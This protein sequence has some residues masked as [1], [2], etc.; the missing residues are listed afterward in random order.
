VIPKARC[1]Y[2]GSGES[3]LWWLLV[4]QHSQKEVVVDNDVHGPGSGEVRFVAGDLGGQ[5]GVAASLLDG[6]AQQGP[7][8][9]TTGGEDK[10]SISKVSHLD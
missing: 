3:E 2:A 7:E 10:Q 6:V 4:Q 9:A 5:L 8:A 1:E